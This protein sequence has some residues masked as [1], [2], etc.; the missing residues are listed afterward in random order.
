MI[1]PR[2]ARLQD[3]VLRIARFITSQAPLIT[4]FYQGSVFLLRKRVHDRI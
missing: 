4:F 2:A 3:L 1:E